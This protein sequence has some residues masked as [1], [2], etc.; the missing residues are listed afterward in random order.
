[1]EQLLNMAQQPLYIFLL[2]LS[3]WG[4]H[5]LFLAET[6]QIYMHKVRFRFRESLAGERKI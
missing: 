4:I 6:F 2:I 3:N 5:D 1:M